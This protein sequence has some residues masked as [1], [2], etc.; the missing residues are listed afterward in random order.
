MIDW[1]KVNKKQILKILIIISIA[2]PLLW[3]VYEII[4][5]DKDSVVLFANSPVI[6]SIITIIYYLLLLIWGILW[7]VKQVYLAI[8]LK[9]ELKK[10]ELLHLNSQ[11]NPHFFFNTLNNLYGLVGKDAKQAQQLILKLSEMMRYSIYEGE[12]GLVNLEDEVIYIENYITLHKMRY[13]KKI[14]VSF[15]KNLNKTTHK[16]MPLTFINLVENAFKHGVENLRTEAFVKIAITS[17]D[18]KVLFK[19]ENNFDK[20]ELPEKKGIGI[21]NLKR[22]LELM[23]PKKHELITLV[24]ENV[25]KATLEIEIR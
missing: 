19:I 12:K 2:V 4:I 3:L 25:F 15:E 10:N 8:D 9:N 16:I 24:E 22:R 13:F 1:I 23:Y 5:L 20:E 11:V 6:F 21:K 17:N 7:L 18:K 14:E